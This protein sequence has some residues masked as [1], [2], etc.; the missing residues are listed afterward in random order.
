MDKQQK[1]GIELKELIRLANN[2]TGNFESLK[3]GVNAKGDNEIRASIK[4]SVLKG[5]PELME[6]LG[7]KEGSSLLKRERVIIIIVNVPSGDYFITY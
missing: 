7:V 2:D 6:K 3:M 1:L 4:S 5:L